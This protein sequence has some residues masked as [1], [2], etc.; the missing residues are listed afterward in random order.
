VNRTRRINTKRGRRLVIFQKPPSSIDAKAPPFVFF[1]SLDGHCRCRCRRIP[2]RRSGSKH[3]CRRVWATMLR[4]IRCSAGISSLNTGSIDEGD[5]IA[6]A[7]GATLAG[8]GLASAF[9]RSMSQQQQRD[10][11]AAA[12]MTP[13][14]VC[15]CVCSNYRMQQSIRVLALLGVGHAN[16]NLLRC[17]FSYVL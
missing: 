12:A 15:V 4:L 11:G 16:L 10:A 3:F 7:A 9:S 13:R 2:G 8:I 5:N 6:L 17:V 1:A 14:Y